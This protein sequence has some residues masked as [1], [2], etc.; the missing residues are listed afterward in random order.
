MSTDPAELPNFPQKRRCGRSCIRRTLPRSFSWLW[1]CPGQWT[2][3]LGSKQR[4]WHSPA[5]FF[6]YSP[7]S[8]WSLKAVAIWATLS[9]AAAY[10]PIDPEYPVERIAHILSNAGP[11]LVLV[12][13][14]HAHLAGSLRVFGTWQW[15]KTPAG[16][17]QDGVELLQQAPSHHLAYVIYTSGSTGRPKGVAI[18]HRS[19]ANMVQ[20]SSV[21]ILAA[22]AHVSA[23]ATLRLPGTAVAHAHCPERSR[24]PVLQACF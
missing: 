16:N 5:F 9:I 20:D 24:P 2:W 1:C 11:R 21:Q 14:K 6:L 3:P 17:T 7:S 8:L 13:E 18:E 12:Q 4:L 23:G 22:R 10:V 15:P 19:A